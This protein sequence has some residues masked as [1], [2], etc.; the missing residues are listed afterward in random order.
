MWLLALLL[1]WLKG[2]L[3]LLLAQQPLA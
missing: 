1:L 2:P 3:P